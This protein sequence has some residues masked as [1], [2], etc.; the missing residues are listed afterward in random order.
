MK[1]VGI[2]ADLHLPFT[3]RLYLAFCKATFK[4]FKVNEVVFIGDIFDKHSLAFHEHDPDGMS[5]GDECIAA[6]KA[7][8][9]WLKAFPKAKVCIGNHDARAMRLAKAAGIPV[10][11]LKDFADVWGTPGWDWDWEHIIDDVAYLHGTGNSGP[12]A[13]LNLSI[14]RRESVVMGHTHSFAGVRTHDSRKD[15]IFGMNV[16]CGIDAASYAMAYA[17]D[18]KNKVS[19]GC[20]VVLKGVEAHYIPMRAYP[21][22]EYY[23]APTLP[24]HKR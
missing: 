11:F 21:G 6:E 20:G 24:I 13:A 4:R 19:L 18:F 16:G 7:L 22:Q 17:K 8:Q 1:N 23:S 12:N 3:H 2:V 10:R 15:M 14:A 9:D 5:P